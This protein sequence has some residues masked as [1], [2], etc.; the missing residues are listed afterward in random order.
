M[1][2]NIDSCKGMNGVNI[3]VGDFVYYPGRAGSD[4][5]LRYGFVTEFVKKRKRI[6]VKIARGTR[7]QTYDITD[8][9]T[10]QTD[11]YKRTITVW[12]TGLLVKSN[13]DE[14]EFADPS[15]AEYNI[16]QQIQKDLNKPVNMDIFIDIGDN[17]GC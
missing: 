4:I 17:N 2:P 8:N 3:K 13:F 9:D 10:K 7:Y 16:F 11:F 14:T 5:W 1:Q 12:K 6:L 15:H